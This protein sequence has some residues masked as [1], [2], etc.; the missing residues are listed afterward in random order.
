MKMT[1]HSAFSTNRPLTTGNSTSTAPSS[2]ATHTHGR[3]REVSV[4]GPMVPDVNQLR[5]MSSKFERDADD[6]TFDSVEKVYLRADR[7][8]RALHEI[9]KAIVPTPDN[10]NLSQ[11]HPKTPLELA[12][13]ARA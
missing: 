10:M 12:P 9:K 7:L 2:T 3:A 6:F 13:K 11:S 1:S 8:E 4:F 5:R